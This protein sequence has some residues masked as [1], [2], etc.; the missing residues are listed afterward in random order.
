MNHGLIQSALD[1]KIC[2]VTGAGG[3]IGRAIALEFARRGA[4]AVAVCD[5]NDTGAAETVRLVEANGARAPICA[6][7]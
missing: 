5:I 7:I 1:G 4:E 2:L 3:R 6:A